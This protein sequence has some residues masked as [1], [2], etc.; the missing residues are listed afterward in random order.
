MK[1]QKLKTESNQE[2][3]RIEIRIDFLYMNSKFITPIINFDNYIKLN[4]LLYI[5]ERDDSKRSKRYTIKHS[6]QCSFY[7]AL[8]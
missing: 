5:T 7:I 2:R 4:H 3:E 1:L 8:K 6:K